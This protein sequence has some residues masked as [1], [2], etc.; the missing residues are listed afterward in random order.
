MNNG[1]LKSR[2]LA[3]GCL[4]VGGALAMLAGTQPWWLGLGEGVAVKFTG[5]QVTAGLSQALAIVALAGTLLMLGLRGRG[6]RVMGAVLLLVGIGAALI[7]GFWMQPRADAVRGQLDH[8]G[9]LDSYRLTATVWPWIFVLAGALIAAGG[10]STLITAGSWPSA[11]GRFQP[12]LDTARPATSEEPAELWKAM[13]AGLDPTAAGATDDHDT[14]PVLDPE[15]RERSA[16]DTMDG[17]EQAQQLPWAPTSPHSGNS[18]G[19]VQ[20]G[21]GE[22]EV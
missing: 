11:T 19:R 18:M 10:A 4:A 16:G 17:T 9:W 1:W 8:V 20:Q 2:G 3:L 22:R 12:E 6:R 7:G 15:V 5:S 13:D 21:R 14:L